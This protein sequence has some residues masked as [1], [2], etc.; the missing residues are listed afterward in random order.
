MALYIPHNIFHLARL[1]YVRPETFGPYYVWFTWKDRD[2]QSK[3]TVLSWRFLLRDINSLML[4][5]DAIQQ[6]MWSDSAA[7]WVQALSFRWA[8]SE[9]THSQRQ[10]IRKLTLRYAYC[11]EVRNYTQ[12]SGAE[13]RKENYASCLIMRHINWAS[14]LKFG[15]ICMTFALMRRSMQK[16]FKNVAIR[17]VIATRLYW[18]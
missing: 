5:H 12:T 17:F 9:N 13:F 2:I 10:L 3:A 7:V 4:K 11:N 15:Y 14:I 6:A 8:W 16:D 18:R 1:L